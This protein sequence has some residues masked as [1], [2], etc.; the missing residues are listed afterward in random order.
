MIELPEAHTLAK[1]LN[2]AYIGKTI[3]SVAA[4]TSPHGFAWY[5]GDPALY[6]EM[7]AGRKISSTAAYAGRPEMHADGMIVSFFDGVRARYLGADEKRPDKHQLLI[8]FDDGAALCCTVQMYGGMTAFPDEPRNDFYYNVGREK[9][10]PYSEAFNKE[11]F[12]RLFDG[13]KKSLSVKALLATEQRIPGLGNGVLQDILFDARLHPKRKAESLSDEERDALYCSIVSILKEMRDGGGRDT[14]K[15]LF[16]KSGGYRTVLSS[17]TLAY[18]CRVCGSGL[19][20]E[21]FLGGNIYFCPQCQ[22]L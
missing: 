1:Q 16:G 19:K 4:N 12:S 2:Q 7:L 5:S 3:V 21:A 11:Y 15:D 13:I 8:E 18:P 9:P 14:E 10:S 6:N 17:K 20:R 22:A